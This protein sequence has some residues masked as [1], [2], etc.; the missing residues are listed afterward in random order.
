ML[1]M[2]DFRPQDILRAKLV[3]AAR[4]TIDGKLSLIVGV[5]KITSLCRDLD[6][7]DSPLFFPIRGVESE[8]DHLPLD[9]SLRQLYQ[10]EALAR[11]DAELER[12]SNIVRKGVLEACERILQEFSR[13]DLCSEDSAN[14]E[15]LG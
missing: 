1:T 7:R 8:T 11:A 4:E 5:R 12:Y 13:K 3:S 15:D 9:L 10:K 14:D 2:D 6:E